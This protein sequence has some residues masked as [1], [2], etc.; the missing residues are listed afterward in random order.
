MDILSQLLDANLLDP[1]ALGRVRSKVAQGVLLEDA[2]LGEG[3][4][5]ERLLRF[6]AELLAL[7]F[8]ELDQVQTPRELLARFPAK[9]LVRR[10][11]LPIAV[12]NGSVLV[13][14][15][16]ATDS[17][18]L[19]ELRIASGI[20]IECVLATSAEIDRHLKRL[21]GVGADTLQTL[22]SGS[23]A[24]IQV[25]DTDLDEDGDLSD[26][27]QNASIIT[28]VNQILT[29]AIELRA[30]DVH[31][32][33]FENQLRIRYRIDGVL[34]EANVPPEVRRFQAAIVSRIKIL[35]HLDIAE[36]RLPQDGRIRLKVSGRE[37]DVRVS[38][39]P[40]LHG[41]A[42][43][44]RILLRND[45]VLG[46]EHLGMEIRDRE[47]FDRVLDFPH[48]IVLVTGPTGSGKT[49][50]LYAALSKI[51]DVERKIITIED[52]VEYQLRGI[53]QIQ[54]SAKTGLTFGLGLRSILRHDPD[55]ILVGEIRDMETAEIAVQSSLTGHLVFSTL[56]TN[57]AP[58]AATRLVD[59]GVEPYLVASS[60]EVVVAQRLVRIICGE[61]KEELPEDDAT[62]LRRQFGRIVPDVM[63][64]GRG[65]RRCLGMG[66]RGRTGIFEMMEMTDEIR[67]V[68]LARASSG[69]IRRIA[70][71]QGMRTLREDG[72]RLVAEGRTSAE[73]ILRATKEDGL[74]KRP[75]AAAESE[76]FEDEL[77][78]AVS[79]SRSGE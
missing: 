16:R 7:P 31:V 78:S 79:G 17:A 29:E 9:V 30:T 76:P 65:C 3:I 66:Y 51:N 60:L 50:T 49:T 43:V 13:A 32:E 20:E 71:Q 48:G 8:V 1:E 27:A 52:P 69:D 56:H 21:L 35:S 75:R 25:L 59:V 28:L 57:D 4:D 5:E 36:K 33:P 34:K 18:A 22:V 68:V 11:L 67:E 63:Y 26:A 12:K 58:G 62:V 47:A 46:T 44:L 19:D 64:R 6:F 2:L 54:V 61:C 10:R 55:V 23:D 77:P 72:W 38:V 73:E 42:V 70:L 37:V 15:S 41:E 24:G 45:A 53:N 40:M 14:T 74:Q 39:I